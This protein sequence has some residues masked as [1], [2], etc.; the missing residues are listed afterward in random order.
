MAADYIL[1]VEKLS[2]RFGGVVASDNISLQVS[3]GNMHCIIGPNGAGKSTFFSLLCGIQIPDSGRIIY[4]GKDITGTLRSFRVKHGLGLTFQTNRV[5]HDLSVRQNLEIPLSSLRGERGKAAD[6]RYVLAL[7]RFDLDP[8][9]ETR[10]SEIP[11][12]KRQ[13]LEIAMVL[14][15]GPELIL[16][17]EPTAGMSPEE[18]SGTARVLRDLNQTGLTIMVVEHDMSFVREVAQ[19]VTVLHQGRVFADGPI[20]E[21]TARQDVRDIYLGRA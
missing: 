18:T 8:N 10:A 9:D 3:T 1:S 15:G 4:K 21:V 17:D 2:K 5:F 20:D 19:R 13:W 16:L 12:H 14:A 7:K 11:H 6:E